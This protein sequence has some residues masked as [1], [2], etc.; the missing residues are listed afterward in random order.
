ME[1]DVSSHAEYPPNGTKLDAT[2][3]HWDEKAA[4]CVDKFGLKYIHWLSEEV[5]WQH[6]W[7]SKVGEVGLQ[8]KLR[9]GYKTTSRGK[10]AFVVGL[11]SDEDV[12]LAKPQS[13]P[14]APAAVADTP[15]SPY[16][17]VVAQPKAHRPRGERSITAT[18]ADAN[19]RELWSRMSVLAKEKGIVT[20]KG[21]FL[22]LCIRDSING[23][24]VKKGLI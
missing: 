6:E 14:V 17:V 13:K 19:E 18:C 8:L 12:V 11:L 24:A 1:I 5:R 23:L 16:D 20:H 4:I 7:R 10:K 15:R 21:E 22:A 3:I 2:V 9:V